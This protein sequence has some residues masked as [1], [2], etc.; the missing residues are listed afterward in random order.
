[1]DE[2][3][4]LIPALPII[5][6]AHYGPK[7]WSWFIENAVLETAGWF[8]DSKSGIVCSKEDR[9]MSAIVQE[10][11]GGSNSDEEAAPPMGTKMDLTFLTG[12]LTARMG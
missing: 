9:Q 11:E 3:V 7:A 4:T 1:M 12:G 5:M 10:Y 8:Y 2:V 6:A